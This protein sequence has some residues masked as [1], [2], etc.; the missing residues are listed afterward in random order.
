MKKWMRGRKQGVI[1]GAAEEL[2]LDE[3][4]VD[5]FDRGEGSCER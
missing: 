4:M 2:G 5:R 1:G 3:T